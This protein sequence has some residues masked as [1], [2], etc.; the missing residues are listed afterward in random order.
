[1]PD[2]AWRTLTLRYG[3]YFLV[4]AVVNEIV[5]RTQSDDVWV[6][7]KTGL[8][9]A[10]LAFSIANVPFMMKHMTDPDAPKAPEPPDTGL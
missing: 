2:A 3:A 4:C 1:M 5:W 9:F 7:F 10:A 8:F 6:V